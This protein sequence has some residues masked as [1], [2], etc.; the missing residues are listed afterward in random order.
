MS[1]NGQADSTIEKPRDSVAARSDVIE[2]AA[3]D[4]FSIPPLI[5]RSVRRKLTSLPSA[6][7]PPG[8]SPVHMHILK[9]LQEGPSHVNTIGQRLLITG[10]HMT[11]LVDALVERGMVDRRTDPEDRRSTNL[12]LTD[13][14][15]QFLEEHEKSIMEG[16]RAVLSSLSV[17][18]L[19]EL[20]TSLRA[21]RDTLLKLQ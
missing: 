2:S 4:L 7:L 3:G 10:P 20:S 15:K 12:T 21:L 18:E 13:K 9:V 16:I 19:E 8:I 5:A 17:K 11:H 14:G 6:D 1:T